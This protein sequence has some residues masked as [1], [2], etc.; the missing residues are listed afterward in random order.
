MTALDDGFSR[1]IFLPRRRSAPVSLVLSLQVSWEDMSMAS[2]LRF[3]PLGPNAVHLCVDMQTLFA[4]RTDWHVPWL[5]CVLPVVTRLAEARRERTVFTRFVPP[6]RPEDATG[7][8]RRYYAHWRDTT[9]ERLDPRLIQ[10]VPPLAALAPP[11]IVIDKAHY[12]PFKEPAFLRAFGRLEADALVITG[13][14]S[15]VCVLATVM[16]AV[17]A[18]YRV[19]LAEDA[20]CSVSDESH[21][22]VLRHFGSRFSQ[23]I[24]VASTGEILEGWRAR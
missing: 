17:D 4:E 11:A 23:Q 1:S 15:D 18:G 6:E 22:A 21:D 13:G 3:G 5:E 7:A 2:G 8:W 14:E 20:L 12:S 24:E 10:L 19:I 16:D 9:G